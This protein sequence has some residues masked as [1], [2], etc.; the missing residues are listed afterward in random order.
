MPICQQSMKYQLGYVDCNAIEMNMLDLPDEILL[1]ILKKMNVV[2]AL[3]RQN[4]LHSRLDQLLFDP[5]Y[6]RELDFTIKSWDDS[7]SPMNDL[8]IDRVCEK[9][10][11]YIND[12]IIKLTLEP[13]SIE[14]VL[15][16]VDY[17]KLSSLSLMNF[18]KK[19]LQH[20][21]GNDNYLFEINKYSISFLGNPSRIEL[22]NKQI[23]HLNID[24]IDDTDNDNDELNLFEFI[25]SLSKCLIDLTF[26]QS[27][28]FEDRNLPILQF[29]STI[30]PSLTKL[31]IR[32]N[33]LEECL[34]LFDGR[35]PSLSH[36]LV[37]IHKIFSISSS[38]DNKV[39]HHLS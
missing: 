35:F 32:L 22:M 16:V 17:P 6:V 27:T 11:P 24:I 8:I 12:K 14:R 25:L 30:Y 5:V 31:N 38:I 18:S 37:Y 33:T 29:S 7:I 2:D 1:L 28:Q 26:H 23:T 10:L 15:R 9:I 34:F 13:N 39:S 20:F 19:T 21:T 4:G 36:C 3:F